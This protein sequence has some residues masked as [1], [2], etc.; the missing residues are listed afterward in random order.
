MSNLILSDKV[1]QILLKLTEING[2]F[3]EHFVVEILAE[4]ILG[5]EERTRRVE[6]QN[7]E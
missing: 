4:V 3:S 6:I 5:M 1:K 7:K 2:G